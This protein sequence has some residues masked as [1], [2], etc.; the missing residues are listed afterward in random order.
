MS[1][2]GIEPSTRRLRVVSRRFQDH[3]SLFRNL[4]D[5]VVLQPLSLTPASPQSTAKNRTELQPRGSDR[6]QFRLSAPRD[7]HCAMPVWV[8][9]CREPSGLL[10]AQVRE[11]GS[12]AR[13]HAGEGAGRD[14][15]TR[16]KR[17]TSSSSSGGSRSNPRSLLYA[18][19]RR[20]VVSGQRSLEGAKHWSGP[21]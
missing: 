7:F 15:R 3:T 2:E 4:G 6:D 20:R 14:S 21:R 10:R 1:R 5:L 11:R 13:Q 16:R 9:E 18:R 12:E 19:R 17:L 8:D